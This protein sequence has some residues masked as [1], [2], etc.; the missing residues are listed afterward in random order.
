MNVDRRTLLI[1]LAAC[2]SLPRP[3]LADDSDLVEKPEWRSYFAEV[4]TQGVLCFAAASDGVLVSDTAR[5]SQ[6]YLPASTFKIA[7]ALIALDVGAAS[8]D[9]RFEW[10][11]RERGIG[12]QTVAAWNKSQT[13]REAFQNST[14]WVFQDV[15]RRVGTERMARMVQALQYGNQD[16]GGAAIDQCWLVPES[17]LRISALQQVAFLERLWADRLPVKAT[18]IAAVRDL[19]VIER[20]EDHTLYGKTGWSPEQK[21]GWL[22]GTWQQGHSHHAFA[23]N[24]DHDG[25][26]K[27]SQARTDIVK[28][29]AADLAP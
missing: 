26:S 8:V 6:P 13:L 21:I 29:A 23:L 24:L 4:G 17:R 12:G 28:R 22:V 2:A 25:S 19:M 3:A 5:A 10:D 15:A 9:E 16:I 11:G 20:D 1:A 18:V 14:I 7:N 27:F